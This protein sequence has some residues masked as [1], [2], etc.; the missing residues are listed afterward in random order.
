[1]AEQGFLE[2]L[3][4]GAS[5]MSIAGLAKMLVSFLVLIIVLAVCGIFLYYVIKKKKNWNIKVTIKIPRS[6][7]SYFSTEKAKGSY[8]TQQG[9]VEIKRKR[10]KP[11]RMK[12]FNA[13]RYLQ[14]KEN[15]LEVMQIAPEHYVPILPESYTHLE[16]DQTGEEA[17]LMKIKSDFSESK[18]WRNGAERSFKEAYT[19]T[20]L[21]KEY[22]P[23]ITIGM[24]IV[25]WG[26]QFVIMYMKVT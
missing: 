19:I 16:D 18:A 13:T 12:P 11:V 14:G 24:V 17:A 7:G 15:K 9:V 4:G 21:L 5:L 22:A 8:N 3:T 26:I 25:L 20:S 10:K 23:Y 1:M 6:E 2:G